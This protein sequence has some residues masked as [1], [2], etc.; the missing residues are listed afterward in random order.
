[1]ISNDICLVKMRIL[2]RCLV[3][4]GQLD[5]PLIWCS[6][7]LVSSITM[8]RPFRSRVTMVNIVKHQSRISKATIESKDGLK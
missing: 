3:V 2:L 1:M 6:G 5:C 4:E 8:Y 7:N